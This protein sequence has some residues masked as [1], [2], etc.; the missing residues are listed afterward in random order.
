MPFFKKTAFIFTKLSMLAAASFQ[1]S[2]RFA[3]AN[4]IKKRCRAKKGRAT[5]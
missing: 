1:T 4:L 2:N 5:E 3:Y